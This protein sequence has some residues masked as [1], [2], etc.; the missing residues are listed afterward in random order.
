ML[1]HLK[2]VLEVL[3]D[4]TQLHRLHS[5]LNFF[6]ELRYQIRLISRSP[7]LSLCP[8]LLTWPLRFHRLPCHHLLPLPHLLFPSCPH[9]HS[10]QLLA[11]ERSYYYLNELESVI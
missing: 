2:W 11:D 8:F 6:L 10:G 4:L 3:I 5:D 7:F 9:P 1:V